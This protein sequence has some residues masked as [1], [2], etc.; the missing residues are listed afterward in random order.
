MPFETYR[1]GLEVFGDG[2]F[3]NYAATAPL[4]RH[5]IEHMKAETQAMASP[6]GQRFYL[7]LNQLEQ[8]RRA[9]AELV[10]V[11]AK[12]IAFTVNTSSAISTIALALPWQAGDRVLVPANEFPSNYYPWLNLRSRGVLC[13]KFYPRPDVPLVESLQKLDLAGVRLISVSAVSYE[14]GRRYELQEFVNFCRSRGIYSCLDCIQAIGAVPLNLAEL[15]VDFACSGAQKWLMGPVGCGMIYARQQHLESL[16]VPYL[17][18]T[19]V[20]YPENF[21]LGPLE[22][23]PEMTRFEPGLPNY[24]SV[25]GM[26]ASLKQL[27]GLGWINIYAAI[28]RNTLYLQAGLRDL[29]LELLTRSRDGTA[30]IVSFRVPEGFD[31]R[32]IEKLYHEQNVKITARND[33]V[34]VSPHFFNLP[35]ELDQFLRATHKI[36]RRGT[37][38]SVRPLKEIPE[39][40]TRGAATPRILITGAT[41]NLGS[42]LAK[43]LTQKGYPL[44]LLGFHA[45]KMAALVDQLGPT[46][47]PL[48]WDLV[49]FTQELQTAAFLDQLQSRGKGAYLGLIHCAGQEETA[50]FDETSSDTLQHLLRVN[51]E[52]PTRLMHLFL[53]ELKSPDALGILNIVSSTGRCGTPLLSVY[54][55]THGALW[56]LGESLAREWQDR[57]LCVTTYVAPPM[58]SPMQKRMGRVSLRFFKMSGSFDYEVVEWVAG[59]AL[60]AFFKGR[61]LK[62][63]KLSKA[64]LFLNQLLPGVIDRKVKKVWRPD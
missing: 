60:R 46:P 39:A 35:A 6:L 55:A 5:V 18:W 36:F 31:R 48:L 56:A 12:E 15:G 59:E 44:H 50:L 30:G 11:Q 58:H 17:G 34:R 10:Q 38:A 25:V 32:Q 21:D 54:S 43:Q 52:V 20:K 23:A 64:K 61:T 4:S 45:D 53:R 1:Q 63:S 14:T 49:D 57:G 47:V 7:A 42:S 51:L 13:E 2:L 9:F 22:F 24:L 26:A 29:G 40:V 37:P 41:G 3:L 27:H 62:I 16:Q 33:Y 28:R 19:S 8:A